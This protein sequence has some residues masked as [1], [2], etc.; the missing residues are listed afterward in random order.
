MNLFYT[1]NDRPLS[2]NIQ[3]AFPKDNSFDK[4]AFIEIMMFLRKPKH[5]ASCIS[6][7]DRQ[8]LR[9][10]LVYLWLQVARYPIARVVF[11]KET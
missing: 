11:L 6:S 1:L 9:R 5:I 7:R 10:C 4:R 2:H 3:H 8:Y